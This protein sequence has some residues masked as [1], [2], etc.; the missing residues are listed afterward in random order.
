M[1]EHMHT[2]TVDDWTVDRKW[3]KYKLMIVGMHHLL[4]QMKEK[5]KKGSLHKG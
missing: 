2:L 3:D 1:Y 4:S 5:K